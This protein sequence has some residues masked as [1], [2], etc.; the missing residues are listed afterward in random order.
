[1][2]LVQIFVDCA[3]RAKT[4]LSFPTMSRLRARGTTHQWVMMHSLLDILSAQIVRGCRGLCGHTGGPRRRTTLRH[5][6]SPP[7]APSGWSVSPHSPLPHRLL[8]L[9]ASLGLTPSEIFCFDLCYP[10]QL[11][12]GLRVLLLLAAAAALLATTT[13]KEG[14]VT[15]LIRGGGPV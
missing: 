4:F 3:R 8:L 9:R 14:D 5:Q 13:Q 6:G 10:L 12:C 1:M 2:V 11:D 15:V 7:T